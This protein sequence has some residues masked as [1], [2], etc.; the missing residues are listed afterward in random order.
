MPGFDFKRLNH[1]IIIYRVVQLVLAALLLFMAYHFQQLFAMIGKPAQFL[2]SFIVAIIFELILLY[3]AYL[4]ARRDANIEIDGCA[5]GVSLD[6][7]A[8]LRKKRL[9]SDLL[10]VSIF[11]F[12]ITFIAM[13][14]DAKK[15]AGA[16]LVLS[17]SIFSFLLLALT[18]FHG[19][20]FCAKKQMKQT[21]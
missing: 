1:V 16:P 17:S 9:R 19:F 3:P 6:T 8:V 11:I 12:F 21:N 5:L 10:K 14:P 18:Y 2:S 4:L 15:S 7:L 20:N 13:A